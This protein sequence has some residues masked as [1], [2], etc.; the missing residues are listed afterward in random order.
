[1]NEQGTPLKILFAEDEDNLRVII[2][3]ILSAYGGFDVTACP[4]GKDAIALLK[5]DKFDI[6]ILD[7]KMPGASGLNVLQWMHEQ[8]MDTPSLVMTGAGT[9][10][11]AVEAMKLGAYDYVRKEH[12]EMDHLPI[13]IRGIYERYLFK[14]EKALRTRVAENNL[15]EIMRF[16]DTIEPI[17]SILKKALMKMEGDIIKYEG[18]LT[19]ELSAESRERLMS[20]LSSI[21]QDQSVI[22][23]AISSLLNFTKSLCENIAGDTLPNVQFDQ[24]VQDKVKKK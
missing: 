22:S 2:T 1:M 9:E 21:K 15:E 11:V 6:V 7:Y 13:L 12:V 10:T 5:N 8:K 18:E 14:K 20:A 4:N 16:N 17:S 19:P 23:F 3:E 24:P